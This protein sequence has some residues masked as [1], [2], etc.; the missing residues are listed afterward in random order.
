[1]R[2]TVMLKV[3]MT[4]KAST[5]HLIRFKW[6]SEMV[7]DLIDALQNYKTVCEYQSIDFSSKKRYARIWQGNIKKNYKG[8]TKTGT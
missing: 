6:N 8:K 7:G 1:M 3:N 2:M 5:T 4:E